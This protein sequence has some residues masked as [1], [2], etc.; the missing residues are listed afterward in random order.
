MLVKISLILVVFS[1]FIF[2]IS[3]PTEAKNCADVIG[4]FLRPSKFTE[5]QEEIEKSNIRKTIK[6]I[7]E[8]IAT[9]I[10]KK[11]I[12]KA[13][14]DDVSKQI[15]TILNKYKIGY[16]SEDI[17]GLVGIVGLACERVKKP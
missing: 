16:D 7:A 14:A 4:G 13:T 15:K 2:D 12:C 17:K 9:E 8:K 10:G 1:L 6:E 5:L 3:H 11:S